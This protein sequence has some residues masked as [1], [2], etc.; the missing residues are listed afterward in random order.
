MFLKRIYITENSELSYVNRNIKTVNINILRANSNV[1]LNTICPYLFRLCITRIQ[2][3]CLLSKGLQNEMDVP[4]MLRNIKR[5]THLKKKEKVFLC[6]KHSLGS[7][8]SVTNRKMNSCQSD[9]VMKKCALPHSASEHLFRSF[10]DFR[11]QKTTRS[12]VRLLVQTRIT[13][14]QMLSSD[15]QRVSQQG[16]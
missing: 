2:K 7:P 4:P 15:Q 6:S 16:K 14:V 13:I 11:S 5:P 10:K 8:R 12:D 3:T 9:A 1:V